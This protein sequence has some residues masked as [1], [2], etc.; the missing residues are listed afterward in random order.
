[1]VVRSRVGSTLVRQLRVISAQQSTKKAQHS[2]STVDAYATASSPPVTAERTRD[3]R[4]AHAL[5]GKQHMRGRS[6]IRSRAARRQSMRPRRPRGGADPAGPR[7]PGNVR[8]VHVRGVHWMRCEWMRSGGPLTRCVMHVPVHET[9]KLACMC[10]VRVRPADAHEMRHAQQQG[11]D[12]RQIAAER[13]RVGD[14]GV[15][16]LLVLLQLSTA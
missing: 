5:I 7:S 10:R 9:C 15:G 16:K 2:Q 12:Q 11:R 8:G 1:M 13:H 14:E 6:P 3:L 4:S